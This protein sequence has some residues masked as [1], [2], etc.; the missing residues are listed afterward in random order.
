MVDKAEKLDYTIRELK[1]M[2]GQELGV[3]D[4]I[5]VTQE[6]IK[7]FGLATQDMDP[8]HVDP[9]WAKENGPFGTTVAHGFWTLSMLTYFS[10]QLK[11][12]PREVKYALN[13]GLNKVRFIEPV[14]TGSRIRNRAILKKIVKNSHNAYLFTTENIIELEGSER[15]ALVA[16]W[17]GLMVC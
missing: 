9:E 3:S 1:S 4:W 6:N 11:F 12:W 17:L 14:L 7:K 8:L 5:E 15:P 16:E 13:Y 10:H 2:V